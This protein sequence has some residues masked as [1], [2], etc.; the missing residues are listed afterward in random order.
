MIGNDAFWLYAMEC[1]GD[2]DTHQSKLN[3][4]IKKK[5]SLPLFSF[6]EIAQKE[7]IRLTP[8]DKKYLL[9]NI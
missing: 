4:I 8:Q 9:D 5:R 2:L 6:D 1:E 7:G 3:R